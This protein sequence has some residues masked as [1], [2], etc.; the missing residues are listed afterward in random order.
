MDAKINGGD[1]DENLLFLTVKVPLNFRDDLVKLIK[2]KL[3]EDIEL[4]N[5]E[6]ELGMIW[7]GR[8]E[9]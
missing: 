4:E 2:N 3:G 6:E 8:T 9:R 5:L 7:N 1:I